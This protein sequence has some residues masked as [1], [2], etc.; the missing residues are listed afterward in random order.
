LIQRK[1]PNALKKGKNR[2]QKAKDSRKG[3]YRWDLL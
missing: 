3:V 2:K 1:I